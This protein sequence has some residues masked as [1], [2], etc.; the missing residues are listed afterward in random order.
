MDYE[1]LLTKLDEGSETAQWAAS[2]IRRLRQRVNELLGQDEPDKVCHEC[3]LPIEHRAKMNC[4]TALQQE[5]QR[6]QEQMRE[7]RAKA[8]DRCRRPGVAQAIREGRE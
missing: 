2:E 6:L 8:A 5:N 3:G 7:E 4:V 1:R